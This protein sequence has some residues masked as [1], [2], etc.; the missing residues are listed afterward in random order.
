M[1]AAGSSVF[2]CERIVPGHHPALEQVAN[3][4]R[5]PHRLVEELRL[6]GEHTLR[7]V[8]DDGYAPA[9]DRRARAVQ[10]RER[11]SL[12]SRTIRERGRGGYGRG[13]EPAEVLFREGG[14]S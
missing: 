9:L 3:A 6:E 7:L 2:A 13:P 1:S 14:T 4:P 10:P 12:V 5:S 11:N 8:L